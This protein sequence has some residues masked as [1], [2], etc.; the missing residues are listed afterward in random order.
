MRESREEREREIW[1][2]KK[3][4]INFKPRVIDLTLS[5]VCQQQKV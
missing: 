2:R 5:C 1:M 3:E 4:E